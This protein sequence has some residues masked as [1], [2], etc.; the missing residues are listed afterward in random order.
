MDEAVTI[1]SVPV[2]KVSIPFSCQGVAC[3]SHRY[4]LLCCTLGRAWQ[5]KQ[6]PWNL[7]GWFRWL[8]VWSHA[9]TWDFVMCKHFFVCSL[10]L[11]DPGTSNVSQNLSIFNTGYDI[12]RPHIS[13]GPIRLLQEAD[14]VKHPARCESWRNTKDVV[15]S[16][17]QRTSRWL[18]TFS[19]ILYCRSNLLEHVLLCL[20]QDSISFCNKCHSSAHVLRLSFT[21]VMACLQDYFG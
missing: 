10:L 13:N 17:V 11:Q 15:S 20:D 4:D 12:W 1:T 3:Q 5:A 19:R 7:N 8:M 16:L 21:P 9:V 18:E 6:K 14:E 2:A